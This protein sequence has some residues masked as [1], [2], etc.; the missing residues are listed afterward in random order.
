M[1]HLW[2]FVSVSVMGVGMLGVWLG[3]VL[4]DPP[5]SDNP[6]FDPANFVGVINNQY[7]PLI[8]GTTFVYEAETGDALERDVVFVTRETKVILGVTTTVV[9]DTATVFD[10][11]TPG[12]RVEEE[13]AD[14]FA[15]DVEGNVWYFGEFTTSFEYDD[16]GNL[17]GTSTAGSWEAG[18]GDPAAKPGIVMLA[19]PRP[20]DSYQQEFAPGVAE[21]MAKVLRLNASVSVPYGDFENCLDTKEWTP[22]EPGHVEQKFY[23]PGV[24]LV[25]T[26][27]HHGKIVRA[28]L[29]D[30]IKE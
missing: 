24:G 13:T 28:E 21:D 15:Q 10:E 8:P 7:M 2:V 3:P 17:I 20:G 1:K 6:V 11:V 27:E 4:A 18:Q 12:G 30:V 9:Q 16:Q 29:V 23:A 14:W 5:G 19:D 22:L 25:L 26:L